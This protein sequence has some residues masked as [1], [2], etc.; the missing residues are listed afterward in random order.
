M[1]PTRTQI[2][3]DDNYTYFREVDPVAGYV[4]PT[5]PIAKPGSP[6]ANQDSLNAKLDQAIQVFEDN[7]SNWPTLTNAQKDTA[8]RQAQRALGGICRLLRNRLDT[9]GV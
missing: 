2:G 1:A 9:A 6:P 7:Y 8:N 3:E 4:I 5:I